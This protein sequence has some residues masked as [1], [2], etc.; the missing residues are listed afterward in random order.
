MALR[1]YQVTSER[2]YGLVAHTPGKPMRKAFKDYDNIVASLRGKE[3]YEETLKTL[4]VSRVYG[5]ARPICFVE[6][7]P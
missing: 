1:S 4:K 5:E 6:L 7:A 3:H 2:S